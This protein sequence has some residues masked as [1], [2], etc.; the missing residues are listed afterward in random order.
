M[1]ARLTVSIL[2]FDAGQRLPEMIAQARQCGAEVL[3]GVDEAC[4]DDTLTVAQKLADTTYRFAHSGSAIPARMLPFRLAQ[5]PWILSLD[6]DEWL[7]PAM[8][9]VL[10]ELVARDD[11]THAYFPRKWLTERDP[12]RFV[13]ESPWFPDWQLRLFR[14]DASIVYR[15]MRVHA[16]Y[17]AMGLGVFEPRASILHLEPLLRTPADRV[18]KVARYAS[19][20]NSGVAD[21]FYASL[22][23]RATAPTASPHAAPATELPLGASNQPTEL[24]AVRPWDESPPWR[25]H[26]TVAMPSRAPAGSRVFAVVTAQNTGGLR[27]QQGSTG[28][29][30]LNLGYHLK[31]GAGGTLRFD[32]GRFLVSGAVA[33]GGHTRWLCE[34]EPLAAGNYQL[35]WDLVSEGE[36][37]FASCGSPTTTSQLHIV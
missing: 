2:A 8:P 25:A 19:F 11:Y 18:R 30:V 34:I 9:D 17:L 21:E 32:A 23:G 12:L 15:P 33:P 26:I 13:T 29:P 22:A 37:W 1:P 4:T 27:W 10:R 20:G 35:E 6:D 24:L 31:D 28:W 7:D 36:C 5:T 14:N 16:G 3:V